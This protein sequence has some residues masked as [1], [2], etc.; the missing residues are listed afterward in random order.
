MNYWTTFSYFVALGI[1]K[2]IARGVIKYALLPN[3]L[4]MNYSKR[5]FPSECI[6]LVWN[7]QLSLYTIFH[8]VSKNQYKYDTRTCSLLSDKYQ[9]LEWTRKTWRQAIIGFLSWILSTFLR[10]EFSW[11]RI[12]IQQP[13]P[14]WQLLSTDDCFRIRDSF[15]TMSSHFTPKHH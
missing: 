1:N 13:S 10:S 3:A 12:K 2:I 6:F 11:L 14:K 8:T 7:K 5:Y 15:H 9:L 4:A